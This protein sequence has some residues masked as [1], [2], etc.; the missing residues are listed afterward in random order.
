M[1][2]GLLFI[3]ILTYSTLGAQSVSTFF[4]SGS[5]QRVDDALLLD[6]QGNLY[7]SHYQGSNVYKIT[8]S[9]AVNAVVTNLNTPNGLAFDSQANL[10]VCDNIGNRVY[11]YSPTFTPLDTIILSSPSGIIKMMN[12]D[13]MIV[14]TYVG[15][16]LLKLAPNGSLTP[17]HGGSP[18]SGPVGLTYDENGQLY[19]GNFSDRKVYKVFEDSLAYVAT[20]PGGSYLGFITYAQ[21]AIWGTTF[22]QHK[23][24]KIVP[25][26]I[27][28]V[29]L[30]TGLVKGSTDG[31][32]S[33]AR[34]DQPNGILATPSGDT[35]YISDFGTGRIRMITGITLDDYLIPEAQKVLLVYPN[36]TKNKTT[37][38]IEKEFDSIHLKV[39]NTMGQ[40]MLAK[41]EVEGQDYTFDMVNLPT[42]TYYI[43][44]T[45]D[46][47][48]ESVPIVK[49]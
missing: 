27:D 8:P 43:L 20:I 26:A 32:L 34:F 42:G 13:T 19:V 44:I 9:G 35:I 37:L 21:G 10:Y 46:G 14:T 5:G 49:E 45:I 28:S 41:L 48:T 4:N 2:T 36:P 25:S 11:K 18:L 31:S 38:V 29:V 7:G 23:I 24:Y 30:Y 22:N 33:Q 47:Q 40:T 39:V 12:S 1:K 16:Q 17:F 6:A 15:H 3:F